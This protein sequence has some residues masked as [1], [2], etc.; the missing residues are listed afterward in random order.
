M[1]N[2]MGEYSLIQQV[3]GVVVTVVTG[4]CI[5]NILAWLDRR[6]VDDDLGL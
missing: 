1:V 3:F 2:M 4:V 5:W 6:G